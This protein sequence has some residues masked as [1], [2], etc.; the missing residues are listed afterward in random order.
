[1]IPIQTTGCGDETQFI[2]IPIKQTTQIR[3]DPHHKQLVV[4][5]KHSL[6]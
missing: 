5:T 4:K 3:H 6:S 1:M 2:L